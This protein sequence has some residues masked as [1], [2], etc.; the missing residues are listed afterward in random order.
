[1]NIVKRGLLG[2]GVL[3]IAGA[4]VVGGLAASASAQPVN[5]IHATSVLVARSVPVPGI[6][7]LSYNNYQPSVLAPGFKLVS[8]TQEQCLTVSPIRTVCN[9]RTEAVAV[10]HIITPS[11][12]GNAVMTPFGQ[13]GT[14]TSG[15][16]AWHGARGVF[17]DASIAP[18]VA[19]ST[20][21]FSTP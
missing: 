17:T 5:V 7:S 13:S 15:T 2:L 6:T 18:N 11:V 12:A 4:G 10:P 14:I 19:N 1:M 8:T 3:G 21:V 16:G 9:F 20:L